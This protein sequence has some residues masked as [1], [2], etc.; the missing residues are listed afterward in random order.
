[1]KR[2]CVIGSSDGIGLATARALLAEGWSVVGVSRSPGALQHERYLHFQCDVTASSYRELLREQSAPGF[3]A[4]I[5]CAGIG[6]PLALDDLARDERVFEVNLLAAVATAAVVLPAMVAARRGQLIVL[7][8]LADV[9]VSSEYPSYSA[10]KAAISSYFSGLAEALRSSGVVV[11][12]IRFG[13]VDT[14]M[15][16][17]RLR[18]F[19]ISREAAAKIVL[20]TLTRRRRRISYPRRMALLVGI[21]QFLQWLKRA[22][23]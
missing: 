20:R 6:E 21:L 22:L 13:F 17:A 8:S 14:K 10:S 3:E 19:M 4:V 7:S 18:P 5:Y 15:A 12:H 9:L 11:S 2:A 16:K 23:G 1:V